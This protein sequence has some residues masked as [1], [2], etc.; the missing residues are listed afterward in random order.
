[1]AIVKLKKRQRPPTKLERSV[2]RVARRRATR[3][4]L[5]VPWCRFRKA[6]VAYPRWLALTLWAQAILSAEGGTSRWLAANLKKRSR[7][8]IDHEALQIEPG[9]LVLR[10]QEWIH[11]RVFRKAKEEGWLDALIFFGV[12][13]LHSRS[14]WAYWEHCESEWET[15]RPGMYPS[16]KKWWETARQY[17]FC[18]KATTARIATALKRYV[19]LQAVIHW[20]HP[21]LRSNRDLPATAAA[22]VRRGWPGLLEFCSSI[23]RTRPDAKGTLAKRLAEWMEDRYFA[24]PRKEGWLN[25]V[26]EQARNEPRHVRM[27]EFW[28]RSTQELP[29]NPATAYPSFREWRRAADSYIPD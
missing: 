25:I 2:E 27:L 10:V 3:Q 13:A 16:F 24:Q 12:R 23:D 29:R 20:L 21:L 6:Y 28:K 17:Q 18:E 15:K 4:L 19:E 7:G 26:V 1:M 8:L 9:L 5:R 11:N 14:A 22:E